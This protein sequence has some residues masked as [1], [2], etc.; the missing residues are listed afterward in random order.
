MT[1]KQRKPSNLRCET[2][3]S[4]GIYVD[5]HLRRANGARHALT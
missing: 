4:M 3:V 1:P 5:A 2:R